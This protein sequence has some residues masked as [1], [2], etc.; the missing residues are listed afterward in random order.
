MDFKIFGEADARTIEQMRTCTSPDSTHSGALMADNHL[1]YSMPI[2]GVIAYRDQV[3]P[4]G[5]GYDIACGNKAVRT[6]LTFGDIRADL[7]GLMD[8]IAADVSFGIGRTNRDEV[9]GIKR[10]H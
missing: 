10:W 6:D 4:S 3:S 5:V 2:G 7:P 1:G 8:T 9:A